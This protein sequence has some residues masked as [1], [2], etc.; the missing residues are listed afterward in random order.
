MSI[1]VLVCFAKPTIEKLECVAV[2]KCCNLITVWV[3]V[4]LLCM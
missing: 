3:I 2:V 1:R 4:G